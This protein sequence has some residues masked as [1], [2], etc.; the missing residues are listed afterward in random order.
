M[1]KITIDGRDVEVED[2]ATI[3]D[4]AEKLGISIPTMCH[5]RGHEP[6]T[7]CMVCVVQVAGA[8]S[9]LPACGTL[10]RDGM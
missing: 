4:A 8:A 10:V 6:V 9:L 5:L 7:S 1:P 3:V 2:G